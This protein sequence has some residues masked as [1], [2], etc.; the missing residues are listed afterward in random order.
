MKYFA[1]LLMLIA[2]LQLDAQVIYTDSIDLQSVRRPDISR[3]AL[4]LD[5]SGRQ[6]SSKSIGSF[7]GTNRLLNIEATLA[8]RDLVNLEKRQSE[9]DAS[10]YFYQRYSSS[11]SSSITTNIRGNSEDRFYKFGAMGFLALDVNTLVETRNQSGRSQ[12]YTNALSFGIGSGRKEVISDAWQAATIAGSLHKQGLITA[13][14]D[15][16]QMSTFSNLISVLRNKRLFDSRLA[17]IERFES[18]GNFLKEY[19]VEEDARF[20]ANLYDLWIFENF[21]ERFAGKLLKLTIGPRH[22]LQRSANSSFGRIG[23]ASQISFEHYQ[24]IHM[25]WQW[26][27]GVSIAIARMYSKKEAYS[28][29]P[30]KHN[31]F[32]IGSQI[33]AELAWIPNARTQF[34]LRSIL[35]HQFTNDANQHFGQDGFEQDRRIHVQLDLQYFFSPRVNLVLEGDLG[36]YTGSFS[37]TKNIHVTSRMRLSCALF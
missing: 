24:P 10:V 5:I 29:D 16:A 3:Q 12:A 18:I 37:D 1:L 31:Y 14:F 11:T 9:R 4:E 27:Y 26:D 8:F 20:Y 7:P 33:W 19:A 15:G 6:S 35:D 32:D 13:K 23:L 2:V 36:H 30:T 17:T 22:Q 34:S 28:L 25:N 21:K